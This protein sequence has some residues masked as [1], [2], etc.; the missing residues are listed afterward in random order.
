MAVFVVDLTLSRRIDS[1]Y[2]ALFF[3]SQMDFDDNEV[4]NVLWN[5][6]AKHNAWKDL[7]W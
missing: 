7:G 5:A 2:T 1:D 6:G 4:I 3:A